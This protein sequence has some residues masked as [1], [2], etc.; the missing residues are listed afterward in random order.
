MQALTLADFL[1]LLQQVLKRGQQMKK[2]VDLAEGATVKATLHRSSQP[3]RACIDYCSNQTSIPAR[4]IQDVI[5]TLAKLHLGAF[6]A[7]LL[8]VSARSCFHR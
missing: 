3:T 7:Q 2:T 5:S 6:L 8:V 1:S 4:T